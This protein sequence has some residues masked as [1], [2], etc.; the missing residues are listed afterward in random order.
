MKNS[1]FISNNERKLLLF[2]IFTAFI[3]IYYDFISQIIQ[4]YNQQVADT[5]RELLLDANEPNRIKFTYCNLGGR[6]AHEILFW[7]QLLTIPSIYLCLQSN[8]FSCFVIS[9]P[10]NIVGLFSY[11]AWFITSIQSLKYTETQVFRNQSIAQTLFYKIN[12]LELL[13]LAIL[14]VLFIFQIF[15]LLRFVIERFQAKISLR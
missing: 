6:T 14:T 15:I 10:L 5:Q 11:F 4:N 8:R 7:L 13:L 2:L 12:N 3:L 1:I 9:I